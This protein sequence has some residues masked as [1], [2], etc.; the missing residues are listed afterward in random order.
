M[1]T[2]TGCSSSKFVAPSTVPTTL[3]L[4]EKNLIQSLRVPFS[5]SLR[6]FHSGETS[7]GLVDVLASALEASFP[8]KTFPAVACQW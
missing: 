5:L 7:S 3:Y 2:W 8:A 4:L 1:A 6:S